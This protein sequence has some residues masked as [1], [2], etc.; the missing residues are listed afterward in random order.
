MLQFKYK[1]NVETSSLV[2]LFDIKKI[3]F[4]ITFY[5]RRQGEIL[6]PPS[7]M[8]FIK[9]YNNGKNLISHEFVLNATHF[10]FI[11]MYELWH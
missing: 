6:C 2:R 9:N 5:G 4:C 10:E 8:Q 1:K 11:I 3:L 7:F